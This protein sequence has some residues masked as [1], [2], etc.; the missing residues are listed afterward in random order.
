MT[1]DDLIKPN[2]VT[3]V[4][5]TLFAAALPRLAPNMRPT[6]KSALK[7]GIDL[8]TESEGEAEAE[9]IQSLVETTLREIRREL[10]SGKPHQDRRIAVR[11][12]IRHFQQ[13]ARR[14]S[15][16]W[17]GDGSDGEQ[18]YRRHVDRLRTALTHRRQQSTESRRPFIEEALAALAETPQTHPAA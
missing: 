4:G 9:L 8:F 3:L 13:K 15:R 2:V 12:K 11:R 1:V 6:I 5:L 7:V 17:A 18:C 14:R 10:D 16:Q